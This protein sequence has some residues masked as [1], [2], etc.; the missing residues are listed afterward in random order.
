MVGMYGLVTPK[1]AV[2]HSE[3]AGFPI[4]SIP[5]LNI[6]E[7]GAESTNFRIGSTLSVFVSGWMPKGPTF[8]E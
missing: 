8:A 1:T 5:G 4:P 6:A 3:A 2:L 7:A